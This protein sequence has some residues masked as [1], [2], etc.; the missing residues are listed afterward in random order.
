MY[1]GM[2]VCMYVCMYV[3]TH[4]HRDTETQRHRHTHTI[5]NTSTSS[6]SLP[7][8]L[9]SLRAFHQSDTNALKTQCPSTNALKTQCPSTN[10]LKTQCPGCLKERHYAE[11]FWECLPPSTSFFFKKIFL[12]LFFKNKIKSVPPSTGRTTYVCRNKTFSSVSTLMCWLKVCWLNL[13]CWPK[14]CWIIKNHYVED[15]WDLIGFRV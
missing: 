8:L 9:A 10:A 13:V 5:T 14:V 4:T 12:F 15:F 6:T 7:R 11:R 2:Y 3:F 1:V